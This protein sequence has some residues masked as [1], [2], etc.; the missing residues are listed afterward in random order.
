ML[1]GTDI[2]SA[3]APIM[4]NSFSSN[5]APL[6]MS[7]QDLVNQEIQQ[8]V[9]PKKS[10]QQI[11]QVKMPSSN[12]QRPPIDLLPANNPINQHLVQPAVQ[13][14][15]QPKPQLPSFDAS[16]FNKQFDTNQE[17]MR[18]RMQQ[19]MQQQQMQQMMMPAYAYPPHEDGYWDKMVNKKKDI[20]KFMQSGLII[21]FAISIHFLIDFLL[22]HYL[23]THEISFER[24]LFIRMIYP[25]AVIFIAWNI[26][27]H[28]K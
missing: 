26:I 4:D 7:Y 13:Q 2:S 16:S 28:I 6:D 24:E 5:S 27:A 20:W 22:K 10:Q 8:M 3:Y 25:I 17:A 11:P 14:V 21:L 1:E 12:Q 23:E 15:A 18:R 19:Q 9:P